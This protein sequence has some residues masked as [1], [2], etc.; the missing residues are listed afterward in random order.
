MESIRTVV[1]YVLFYLQ[2]REIPKKK[3]N[4]KEKLVAGVALKQITVKIL[5]I[6]TPQIVTVTVQKMNIISV[7]YKRGYETKD[8]DG[9]AHTADQNRLLLTNSV[10][11][12]RSDCSQQTA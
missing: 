8:A 5:K 11:R 4:R 6:G 12:D 1:V 9:T 3:K 10:D 7:F 2:F